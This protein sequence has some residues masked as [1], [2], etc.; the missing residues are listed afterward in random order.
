MLYLPRFA[1]GGITA[2][3]QASGNG[4]THLPLVEWA[5]YEAL[6]RLDIQV[7]A[8]QNHCNFHR[9]D[10]AADITGQSLRHLDFWLMGRKICHEAFLYGAGSS[11]VSI[12]N[13]EYPAAQHVTSPQNDDPP[14]TTNSF[15]ALCYTLGLPRMVVYD[16]A[17]AGQ[18]QLISPRRHVDGIF[19]QGA[20]DASHASELAVMLEAMW[21][22]PVLGSLNTGQMNFAA[23]ENSSR[24]PEPWTDRRF[25]TSL[26]DRFLPTLK[27]NRLMQIAGQREFRAV[28][29]SL[30]GSSQQLKHLR[31]GIAW[32]RAFSRYFAETVDLLELHGAEVRD[33][34]PLADE[35]LP[36]GV[37]MVCLGCGDIENYAA[38]L[39]ANECMKHSIAGYIRR[40]GKVYAEA[41]GLAYL[42]E[43]VKTGK[44]EFPMTGAVP[45]AA[46]HGDRDRR[47]A[48]R[49][50][51]LLR[52]S[53]IGEKGSVLKGYRN[54][55]WRLRPSGKQFGSSRLT[56]G[57]SLLEIDGVIGS[58]LHLS[59]AAH[60]GFV[61]QL[62]RRAAMGR[63]C[64]QQPRAI[65]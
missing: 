27:V 31:V 13:G 7:Q 4:K 34:S 20:R 17:G 40:G 51:V 41:G 21:G 1:L 12:V 36:A 64:L 54:H 18:C 45:A 46:F 29:P 52:D 61:K 28:E 3:R 14:S 48:P 62:S 42:C 38:Q 6:N 33:F 8:F 19:I 5:L 55:D 39:S 58:R 49:R 50:A 59:I 2:A 24:F 32:D 22:A 15:D 63:P 43:S 26:V 16:A 47:P 35:R 60:P 53:W 65:S 30:F 37:N 44:G 56:S 23:L 25:L 57:G 10:A 11:D 9:A